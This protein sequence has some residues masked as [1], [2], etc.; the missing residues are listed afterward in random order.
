MP[1]LLVR[2]LLLS[3]IALSSLGSS[4][5]FCSSVSLNINV[6]W[7]LKK[8]IPK[9]NTGVLIENANTGKVLYQKN[10]T[11][12]YTPAS[13]TKIFTASAA[14]WYLG[15]DFHFI[16][17]LSTKGPVKNGS[18]NGNVYI[19]FS[20]DPT[21][22]SGNLVDLISQ[23]KA[24]GIH[25][26][27]GNVILDDKIFTGPQ[28]PLGWPQDD[29]TYC[30]AAPAT[31][32][33]INQN[34]MYFQ[35]NR[36]RIIHQGGNDYPVINQVKLVGR[37]ALR[38]CVFAPEFQANSTVVLKG[39]LPN[40]PVWN[41]QFA[42]HTPEDYA[43]R[44]TKRL[45]KSQGI[46]VTGSTEIGST[47]YGAK[48]IATHQSASLDIILGIMLKKSDNLYAEAI[49]RTLGQK[50]YGVGSHKAGVNAINAI[51]QKQLGP[52]FSP[53]YLQDGA[54][55]STY[56]LISPQQIAE[57]LYGMY[58]SSMGP[59][60]I[61]DLAI[62][63]K[64]GTLAYRMTKPP[65]GGRVFGKT[66]TIAGVSTLSGYIMLPGHQPVIFSIMMNEIVGSPNRSR[67]AQDQIVTFASKST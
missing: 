45:L 37:S 22:T 9:V 6:P 40:Q 10:S 1:K 21:F 20:G 5:A 12:A 48:V 3:I 30:Y 50:Y 52:D 8:H 18:L 16:T 15:P 28:Y 46:T 64:P 26:I 41:F 13:N 53:P 57:V 29:L 60:F 47:A 56:N 31:G 39:C 7:Y 63:G 25:H 38:T 67:N 55:E 54:G 27:N 42:V 65:L 19:T 49:T 66:G 24:S 32:I 59:I 36:G 17:S 14:L 23:L 51:I 43:I 4:L 35:L 44:M 34:C 33:I 58:H 2:R 11:Q 61:K 62:S